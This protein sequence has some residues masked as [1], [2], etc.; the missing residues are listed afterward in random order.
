MGGGTEWGVDGMVGWDVMHSRHTIKINWT[1]GSRFKIVFG[2]ALPP[3]FSRLPFLLLLL[4]GHLE[5]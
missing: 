4:E 3:E 5:Q 2:V 1:I